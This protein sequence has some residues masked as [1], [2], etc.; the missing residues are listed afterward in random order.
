MNNW[1]PG[2]T[3]KFQLEKTASLFRHGISCF[4]NFSE[5]GFALAFITCINE[6]SNSKTYTFKTNQFNGQGISPMTSFS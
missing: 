6:L 5:A 1:I 3:M 4:N 2:D